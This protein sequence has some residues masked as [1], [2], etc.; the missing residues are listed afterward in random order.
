MLGMLVHHHHGVWFPSA[1]IMPPYEYFL[2]SMFP[3]DD[4]MSRGQNVSDY[5]PNLD[6]LKFSEKEVWAGAWQGIA[7]L[8]IRGPGGSSLTHA[9]MTSFGL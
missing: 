3:I 9:R 1:Q 4:V 6:A 5:M 8:G 7:W 2:P